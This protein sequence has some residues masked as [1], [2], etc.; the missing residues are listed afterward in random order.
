MPSFNTEWKVQPHG[1]VETVDDRIVT[2]EGEIPMPLGKF[3]RR[4]TVVG[5][6]RNRSV[7]FSAIALKEAAMRRIEEVGIPTFLVVPN[8][9]HRLDAHAWKERYPKLRVMCPPAAKKSVSEAV[10]VDSTE[11]ILDD[12]D[13]DFVLVYVTGDA[14]AA[15]V[16]RR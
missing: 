8:G 13:V 5:L 4:M 10:A 11:D 16:V 3:P 15:L 12:K 14:D 9:H 2:V 1:R 6:S 7:V